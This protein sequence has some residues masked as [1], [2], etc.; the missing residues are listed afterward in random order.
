MMMVFSAVP[1]LV[2]QPVTENAAAIGPKVVKVGQLNEMIVWNPLDVETAEDFVAMYLVYS[3]LFNY[4]QDWNGPVGD[5]AR[6]W[7]QTIHPDNTMTTWVNMTHNA[8]FRTVANPTDIAHPLTARDVAYTYKLIQNN[9]GGAWNFYLENVSSVVAVDLYTVR[10]DTNYTKATILDDLAGIPIIPMYLW[11]TDATLSRDPYAAMNPDQG[12]GSG[13][14]LFDSWLR[15]SWYQF[16]TA[17]TYHGSELGRT[18]EIDGIRYT[19]YPDSQGLTLAMN[20]GIEDTVVVTGD[21]NVFRNVL[22]GGGTKV[23]VIKQAVQEPGITDIAINAIPLE[24]REIGY[25]DGWDQRDKGGKLFLL[26]PWVRKAIMMTLD[27]DYVVNNIMYGLAT[28]ADSVIQPNYWHKTIDNQVPFD[29]S[30]AKQLLID[31]GYVDTNGDG[32]QEV[33]NQSLSYINGWADIGDSLTGIRCQAS[34]TD[35]SWGVIAETWAGW[36]RQAGLGF[37]PSV[38]DEVSMINQAWYKAYYDIWVWHAGWGPEPLGSALSV[39]KTDQITPGGENCQM[40]MGPWWYGPLNQTSSPTGEPYSAFDENMTLALHTPDKTQRKVIVDRLQQFIYDSYTEN[41]PMYDLGLYAY[42]DYRYDGWG[43]WVAHPGRSISSGLLWLWFDLAPATNRSPFFNV[44]PAAAYDIV[45]DSP[46]TFS[47]TVS[48]ADGD[49]LLINWTFGDGA[50]AQSTVAGDTTVPKIASVTHTYTVLAT[51]LNMTVSLWDYQPK[52]EL[53]VPAQVNLVSTPNLGPV[54]LSTY[55]TPQ[56]PVYIGTPTTWSVVA[57]D[58]ESQSS[59]YGILITWSWGDGTY[60]VFHKDPLNP[61]N[62]PYNDTRQHTWTTPDVYTVRVSVWDGYD[63]QSNLLHNISW[64][65]VYEVIENTPPS[66]PEISAI[67]GMEDIAVPCQ[68]RSTDADADGLRFTW[69][70]GNDTYSVLNYP[71]NAGLPTASTISHTWID[72]GNYSVTLYIN[73]GQGHNVSSSAVAH[74][75]ASGTPVPPG[76]ITLRMFPNPGKAG[77]EVWVNAS[78]SDAN[79]DAL[80]FYLDFEDGGT[81]SAVTPGGT[82]GLQYVNVSHTYADPGTYTITVNVND[83]FPDGSHNSTSLFNVDIEEANKPPTFSLQST[84]TAFYNH[85]FEISPIT[86]SDPDGDALT[87]WYDWGD[88]TPLTKGNA[89]H[90]ATHVYNKTAT[91][92]ITVAANDSMGHNVSQTVTV[93][94]TDAN[95][96]PT[97]ETWAIEPLK[98]KYLTEET[99]WFNVTVRDYEGDTVNITIDFDDGSP[100]DAKQVA[101]QPDTNSSVQTFTHEFTIADASGYTVEVAVKDWEDHSNMTWAS[102]TAIVIVEEAPGKGGLSTAAI[103]AII[104]IV[105]IVVAFVAPL[106]MRRK[107]KPETGG[108]EGVTP[109][110]ETPPPP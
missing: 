104:A 3:C 84:F 14:F 30:Q 56:P 28:K 83:S 101:L 95:L 92:T 7:N 110:V 87:V 64:S 25:A 26:D 17:P 108:A 55:F 53:T 50:T 19:V 16:A 76:S 60:T 27:K 38:E 109:P 20:S 58:A 39:W 91:F 11:S 15:G 74:I 68:A 18:V 1:M 100:V 102:N 10:I 33:T 40:P 6:S 23:H 65:Q 103:L 80:S 69:A 93:T 77:S 5:L 42:T 49:P 54:I 21:F 98:A 2:N 52:H 86:I 47:V 106:L 41:P 35:P 79:Q 22:G 107:K 67:D 97:I 73:D 75:Q 44:P 78:A 29:T 66:N 63:V 34:D 9:T 99:I 59:H 88:N 94:V 31:H 105:I 82:T 71:P 90:G 85:T 61:N 4:D 96:K 57:R 89:T 51:G 81:A 48:D 32:I 8:H 13:P 72:P 43:D 45:K 37:Q 12:V 62:A 36:A 70:W 46:K 24:F